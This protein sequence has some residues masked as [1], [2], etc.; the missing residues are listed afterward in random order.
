MV[1]TVNRSAWS[2]FMGIVMAEWILRIVPLST[3]D[4]SKF[5]KPSEFKVMLRG[6]D[7]NVTNVSGMQYSPLHP[8][9]HSWK[10]APP[11]HSEFLEL[12]YL[13]SANK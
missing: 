12:N 7:L 6:M 3:H 1:S 9:P 8:H 10:L 13:M 5:I 4:H 11:H 2:Y